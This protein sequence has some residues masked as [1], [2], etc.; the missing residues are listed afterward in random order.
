MKF[1]TFSLNISPKKKTESYSFK[2]FDLGIQDEDQKED[3]GVNTADSIAQ[4]KPSLEKIQEI[5][6]LIKEI[7]ENEPEGE[8]EEIETTYGKNIVKLGATRMN[9]VLALNAIIR[10]NTS[11]ICNAIVELNVFQRLFDLMKKYQFNNIL[12]VKVQ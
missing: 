2:G 7:I 3:E 6:P 12:H 5:L 9:A 1:S 10:L 11:D 4:Y 8:P